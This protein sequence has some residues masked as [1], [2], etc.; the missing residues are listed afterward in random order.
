MAYS[1]EFI[2]W[3]HFQNIDALFMLLSHNPVQSLTVSLLINAWAVRLEVRGSSLGAFVWY[4]DT[5]S[6]SWITSAG[7]WT[8]LTSYSEDISL[9]YDPYMSLT[10]TVMEMNAVTLVCHSIQNMTM[11]VGVIKKMSPH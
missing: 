9:H 2:S 3:R 6:S 11:T 7:Y 8:H 10:M 4:S 5:M 1:E